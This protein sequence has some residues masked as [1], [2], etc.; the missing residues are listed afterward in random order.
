MIVDKIEKQGGFLF[1]WRSFVP[2]VLVPTALVALVEGVRVEAA[3]GERFDNFWMIGCLLL[4]FAGL[5]LRGFTVGFVPSGTSG[6]NT[7]D[8]RAD[9]LNTTGMYSVVRNPLYLANFVI[10][11]GVVLALKVWWFALLFGLAYWLYIERVIAAE[12]R[13]LTERFGEP[14]DSWSARTP[15]FWP[16]LTGWQAPDLRFSPRTVLRREYNGFYAIVCAFVAL[17]LVSDIFYEH[18]TLAAWVAEDSFWVALFAAGTAVFFTIRML[19]KRT[20][21]LRVEGR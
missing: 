10:L 12:E 9:E 8:Q 3:W 20:S 17:E 7:R 16:R 2:L 14:Y 21:L 11:L 13:Y 6:R 19:K 4:S 1:R 18:L 5:A 15:A